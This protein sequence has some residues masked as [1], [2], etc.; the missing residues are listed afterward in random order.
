MCGVKEGDAPEEGVLFRV[1]GG[2]GINVGGS[3]RSRKFDGPKSSHRWLKRRQELQSKTQS[4]N[5]LEEL[6]FGGVG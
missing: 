2:G 6:L 4:E 5:W 3:E 1:G